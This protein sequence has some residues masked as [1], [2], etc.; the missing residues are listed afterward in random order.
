MKRICS[1]ILTLAL[2]LG[3]CACSQK[4]PTWKEQYDLGM[5]YLSEGNY[6]EA[7]IAFTAAIE[8][9]P[10]QALA[11]VGRGNV[12]MSSGTAEDLAAAQEDYQAALALDET[13]EDA[14]IGLIDAYIRLEDY[15]SARRILEQ[16]LALVDSDELRAKQEELDR[17]SAPEPGSD[18]FFR[19]VQ[20]HLAPAV[21]FDF[22]I[23]GTPLAGSDIYTIAPLLGGQVENQGGDLSVWAGLNGPSANKFSWS[24]MDGVDRIELLGVLGSK[25]TVRIWPSEYFA[26]IAATDTLDQALEKL[27]FTEEERAY[28]GSCYDISIYYYPEN[29]YWSL[30]ARPADD[31]VST[32]LGRCCLNIY[33]EN[34]CSY[35]FEYSMDEA[36]L[37][38]DT[39]VDGRAELV[40][41]VVNNLKKQ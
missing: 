14:W 11:Y 32:E 36:G 22:A 6:Q 13:L 40:T 18:G 33:G 12:Y 16:A 4:A 37:G 10:K 19:A 3:L 27:G 31:A 7:I 17:L 34:M 26:G 41:M 35:C 1:L 2:V 15:E 29:D 5:K 8:I 28:L 30:T 39:P 9:D 38:S 24:Q 21:S 25:E 23:D 20:Q